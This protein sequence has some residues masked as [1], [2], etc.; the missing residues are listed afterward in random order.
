MLLVDTFL[1]AFLAW[2][3]E[4]VVPSSFGTKLPPWFFLMPSYWSPSRP[5]AQKRTEER[6][7][8]G[9]EQ[10]PPESEE[11]V[12]IRINNVSK[13]FTWGWFSRNSK[14][15]LQDINMKILEDQIFGLLGH[16]GISSFFYFYLS[17]SLAS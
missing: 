4:S 2:Y 16:N 8:D 14:T 11:K 5:D 3:L 12:A 17:K 7:Q 15:V 13:T 6:A 1:Y 9:V 10:L